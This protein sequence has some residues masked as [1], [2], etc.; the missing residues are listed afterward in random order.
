MTSPLPPG[1]SDSTP[2]DP[3]PYTAGLLPDMKDAPAGTRV[4]GFLLGAGV[5]LVLGL[6]FVLAGIILG[7]LTGNIGWLFFVLAGPGYLT[8]AV[9]VGRWLWKTKHMKGTAVGLIL[10]AALWCALAVTCGVL[11]LANA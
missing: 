8:V 7:N 5:G 1:R 6:G 4:A 11:I 10:A 9:L 2:P 3:A